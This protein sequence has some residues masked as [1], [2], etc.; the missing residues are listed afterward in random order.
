MRLHPPQLAALDAWIEEQ[1]APK[2][3]RPEAIRIA[4]RDWLIGLGM[5]PLDK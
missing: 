1:P 2:P 3:S 4:L 5:L